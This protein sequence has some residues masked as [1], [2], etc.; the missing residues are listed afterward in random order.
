MS[1]TVSVQPRRVVIT[2]AAGQVG[3]CAVRGLAAQGHRVLAVD[4][5][6]NPPE[7]AAEFRQVD[8]TDPV[9]LD[10][11]FKGQEVVIHLAAIPNDADF[12]S[13]L[14]SA[15]YI[16]LYQ[17][18]EAA[19]RAEVQ[20]LI[21]ISSSQVVFGHNLELELVG[22][23]AAYAPLNQYAVSKITM[24]EMG[25]LYARRYG[26]QVL[27]VRP[28]W[29]PTSAGDMASIGRSARTRNFYLSH[30]DAERFFAAAVACDKLQRPDFRVVYA[31]SRGED[32]SIGLDRAPALE[33]LGYAGQ[34]LWP[35]GTPAYPVTA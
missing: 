31:Q 28:G 22:V 13:K 8:I 11:A 15:N 24:E 25:R 26:M 19:R 20:R 32:E 16:G 3:R 30:N 27:V 5:V 4:L 34:D 10:A 18:F 14:L 9:A 7:G 29:L 35:A 12:M 2:G 6:N 17:V 33:L 1:T 21:T 23:D